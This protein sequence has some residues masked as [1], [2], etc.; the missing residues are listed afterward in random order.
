V[1]NPGG[2]H[3]ACSV[4]SQQRVVELHGQEGTTREIRENFDVGLAWIDS[5]RRLA[6]AGKPL[7]SKS[8]AIKR[9]S[10]AERRGDRIM[11]RAVAHPGTTLDDRKA[12]LSLTESIATLCRAVQPWA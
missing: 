6:T 3:D 7:E 4:E 1:P 2:R 12:D 10:L 8:R 5:I 9:T 11:V